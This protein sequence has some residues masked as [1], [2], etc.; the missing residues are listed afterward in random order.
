MTH[1]LCTGQNGEING[2]EIRNTSPEQSHQSLPGCSIYC[3]RS[4]DS[5]GSIRLT[6]HIIILAHSMHK[7]NDMNILL[8]S[9]SISSHKTNSGPGKQSETEKT[10]LVEAQ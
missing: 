8:E 1:G 6:I 3:V 5:S 7:G 9:Q 2:Y 4:R 10:V